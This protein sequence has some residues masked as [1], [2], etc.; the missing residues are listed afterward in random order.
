MRAPSRPERSRPRTTPPR[1]RLRLSMNSTTRAATT[2]EPDR[3]RRGTTTSRSYCWRISARATLATIPT[4][5]SLRCTAPVALSRV[6]LRLDLLAE[7][8]ERARH[9]G[10]DE[11]ELGPGGHRGVLIETAVADEP[12][13]DRARR[14]DRVLPLADAVPAACP[15]TAVCRAS[16]C[17]PSGVAAG[18][19]G[20]VAP[21]RRRA[22]GASLDRGE[23]GSKWS[24]AYWSLRA[25]ARARIARATTSGVACS[26]FRRYGR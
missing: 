24:S 7:A 4:L 17:R 18:V 23:L 19:S 6:D 22:P 11:G 3:L 13:A 20:A 26:P 16:A 25:S 15:L 1:T 2:D 21:T 12:G 9:R 14:R 5:S 8:V 10:A